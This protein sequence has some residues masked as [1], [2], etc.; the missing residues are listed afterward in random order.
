MDGAGFHWRGTNL[1]NLLSVILLLLLLGMNSLPLDMLRV[2]K[3]LLLPHAC[4]QMSRTCKSFTS[5]FVYML[6]LKPFRF[7]DPH[8]GITDIDKR[9]FHHLSKT[10]VFPLPWYNNSFKWQ[11]QHPSKQNVVSL[12]RI[13]FCSRITKE[14]RIAF[15]FAPVDGRGC[16]VE[17]RLDLWS[18]DKRWHIYDPGWSDQTGNEP[19]LVI[20]RWCPRGFATLGDFMTVLQAL[21]VIV[22]FDRTTRSLPLL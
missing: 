9:I 7:F 8:L 19:H 16:L 4:I 22:F 10:E 17:V 6:D 15:D 3:A 2:I 20:Q 1:Q 21:Q 13:W 18:S 11:G 12:Y 5:V 14:P